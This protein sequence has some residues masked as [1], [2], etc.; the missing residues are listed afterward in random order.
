MGAGVRVG[1]LPQEV[2]EALPGTVYD[3]VASGGQGHLDLLQ[4][5]HQLTCAWARGTS[6]A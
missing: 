5:Y 2:P 6:P 3:I 4:R 1:L